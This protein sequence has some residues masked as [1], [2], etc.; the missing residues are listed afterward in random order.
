MYLNSDEKVKI[1]E[2]YGNGQAYEKV[3]TRGCALPLS[4][5]A[6]RKEDEIR[7]LLFQPDDQLCTL[8]RDHIFREKAE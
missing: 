5:I 1:F 7:L 4:A 2:K 6:Y 8:I 3:Y